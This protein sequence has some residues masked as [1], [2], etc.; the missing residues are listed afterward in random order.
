MASRSFSFDYQDQVP[1]A[2]YHVYQDDRQDYNPYDPVDYPTAASPI[3]ALSNGSS[4]PYRRFELSSPSPPHQTYPVGTYP[5]SNSYGVGNVGQPQSRA[6]YL[7]EREDYGPYRQHPQAGLPAATGSTSSSTPIPVP[8][9]P[10]LPLPTDSSGTPVPR[11]PS[12]A[13]SGASRD[14]DGRYWERESDYLGSQG[15]GTTATPGMDNLGETAA[16]GGIAGIA[17]GVA[18]SNERL[19]GVQA[20]RSI[21]NHGHAGPPG[22]APASGPGR[23]LPA[24]RSYEMDP[25]NTYSPTPPSFSSGLRQQPSHSSS[26]LP[27]GAAGMPPGQAATV[28]QGS[29]LTVGSYPS[30]DR[31]YVNASQFGDSPYNRYSATWDPRAES[32]GAADFNPNDIEDDGDDGLAMH[33]GQRK[34]VLSFKRQ[35][36]SAMLSGGA[37]AAAGGAAAGG[38]MGSFGRLVGRSGDPAGGAGGSVGGQYGPVPAAGGYGHDGPGRAAE[39]SEWL[40]RQHKGNSKLK[41]IVGIIV[42]ILLVGAI[43]G[44]VI[45][46]VLGARRNKSSSASAD[47]SGTTTSSRKGE[48]TKDSAE[49]KALMND[50]N[51][52]RVFPGMDYMPVNA[53][54]PECLSN[55]PSQN[56]VTKDMAVLSQLT[57]D[58]RLYG[59]DCNQTE[60]V[61][62]A[63]DALE[64]NDMK[65]WLGVWV[66]KNATTNARQLAHMYAVLDAYDHARFKGVIVGN[67]ILY[68]GD[69]TAQQLVELLTE[70]KTNFTARGIDLPVATS[71]LGDKWTVDLARAV[72]VVMSN[73]HPIFSGETVERAAG[74]TWSFWQERNVRLTKDLPNKPRH[75]IAEVGWPSEGGRKD[76]SVAGIE[77]MNVFMDSFVCASLTNGT[78][79]FWSAVSHLSLSFSPRRIILESQTSLNLTGT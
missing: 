45:G 35:S 1:P 56:A 59:T 24:E 44:G 21:D 70:V 8:S 77:E 19:S 2:Q 9:H 62:H 4:D 10:A 37:K 36:S 26:T 57:R 74:W 51:L 42:G 31:S 78:D 27:L 64:L 29:D 32:A 69:I 71:D 58:V 54:Y 33:E 25:I 72:D 38:L 20:S 68:R 12:Y 5:V 17:L 52:H 67:E 18:A 43:V 61:L 50:G 47:R 3:S 65:V 11:Q 15:T 16:G 73:V 7:D 76:A 55:P 13:V 23:I 39:K 22:Q 48:L 66:D 53:Q 49:I 28:R 79:Y 63:L 34:S 60:L 41:W 14:Q 6:V 46:G 30:Q 40:N 75:I